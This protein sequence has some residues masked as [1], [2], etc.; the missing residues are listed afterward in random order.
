MQSRKWTTFQD[1]FGNELKV[2]DFVIFLEQSTS[3]RVGLVRSLGHRSSKYEYHEGDPEAK[4]LLARMVSHSGYENLAQVGE[5]S[6][7]EEYYEHSGD[8]HFRMTRPL[9]VKTGAEHNVIKV[10]RDAL[11]PD[12]VRCLEENADVPLRRSR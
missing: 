6:M 5:W 9:F 11:P 8:H 1:C 3:P 4:I 7:L 2:G 10:T 12:A